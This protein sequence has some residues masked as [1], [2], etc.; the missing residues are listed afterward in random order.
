M[1]RWSSQLRKT[2]DYNKTDQGG[3]YKI[4]GALLHKSCG[5]FIPIANGDGCYKQ[6]EVTGPLEE[7]DKGYELE[8]NMLLECGVEGYRGT[9][10]YHENLGLYKTI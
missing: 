1:L 3:N 10:D 4:E 7:P 5:P 8:K 6:E 2:R 9:I